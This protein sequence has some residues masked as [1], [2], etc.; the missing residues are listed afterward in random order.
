MILPIRPDERSPGPRGP[1]EI[2]TD[3]RQL[4][5][6]GAGRS[7]HTAKL[8]ADLLADS[9]RLVGG[10]QSTRLGGIR[11]GTQACAPI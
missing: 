5:Q 7:G 3:G 1:D 8:P 4:S 9:L 10:G 2:L 6:G 11:G